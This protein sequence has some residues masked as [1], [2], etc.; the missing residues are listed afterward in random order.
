MLWCTCQSHTVLDRSSDRR[1]SP[2]DALN[3]IEA[4]ERRGSERNDG[5]VALVRVRLSTT[6][7]RAISSRV[8]SLYLGCSLSAEKVIEDDMIVEV[9]VYLQTQNDDAE[10]V[11]SGS[12]SQNVRVLVLITMKCCNNT[13]S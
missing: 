7:H 13:S 9:A 2:P 1:V 3:D 12:Q 8:Q 10:V 4:S 5:L 11:R 6:S